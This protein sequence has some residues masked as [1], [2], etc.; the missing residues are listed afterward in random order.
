MF[1]IFRRDLQSSKR[2]MENVNPFSLFFVH[3]RLINTRFAHV[4]IYA[5]V[6]IYL[7]RIVVK[8]DKQIKNNPGKRPFIPTVSINVERN[9]PLNS[10]DIKY[11]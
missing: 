2:L 3:A 6:E 9:R 11:F 10:Q 8:R 4:K 5:A 1:Q 7:Y